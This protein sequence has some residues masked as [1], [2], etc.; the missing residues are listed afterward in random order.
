MKEMV[1]FIFF[2]VLVLELIITLSGTY[3]KKV[4]ASQSLSKNFEMSLGKFDPV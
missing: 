3:Y 2:K 1:S 4:K